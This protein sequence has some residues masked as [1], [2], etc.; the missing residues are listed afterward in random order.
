MPG[1]DLVCSISWLSL[2][3]AVLPR[4]A[5]VQ[6]L[7]A[8]R[9]SHWCLTSAV[10]ELQHAGLAAEEREVREKQWLVKILI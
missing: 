2:A 8:V 9:V 6:W 3:S 4:P 7:T 1:N 5:P 10:G